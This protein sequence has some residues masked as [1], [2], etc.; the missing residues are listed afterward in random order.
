VLWQDCTQL[1]RQ[2]QATPTLKTRNHGMP[3]APAQYKPVVPNLFAEGSQ[4]KIYDFVR[5]SH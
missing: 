1:A 4:I 2:G 3:V 5:E